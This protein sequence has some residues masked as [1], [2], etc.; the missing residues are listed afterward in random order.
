MAVGV[1]SEFPRGKHENNAW[2]AVDSQEMLVGVKITGVRHYVTSS[3]S[4][5]A[6]FWLLVM[7]GT[8]INTVRSQ[9]PRCSPPSEAGSCANRGPVT[10]LP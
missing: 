7:E 9:P 4:V 5:P 6:L 8:E 1:I 10:L 2:H 3:D